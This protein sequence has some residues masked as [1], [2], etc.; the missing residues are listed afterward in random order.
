[1]IQLTGFV[2]KLGFVRVVRMKCNTIRLGVINVLVLLAPP[3]TGKSEIAT[4]SNVASFLLGL[5][6]LQYLL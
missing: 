1:M 2:H 4:H 3:T 5:E 6:Y